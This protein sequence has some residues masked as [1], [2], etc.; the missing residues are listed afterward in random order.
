MYTQGEYTLPRFDPHLVRPITSKKR[1][2]IDDYK[3]AIVTLHKFI[4]IRSHPDSPGKHIEAALYMAAT[5]A[6]HRFSINGNP[7]YLEEAIVRY[8]DHLAY[9]SPGSFWHE[10]VVQSLEKL[11]R[12]RSNLFGVANNL[13]GVHPS[14]PQVLHFRPLKSPH[15]AISE[16]FCHLH[17]YNFLLDNLESRRH[18][19]EEVGA[20]EHMY[21]LT[22]KAALKRLPII[23]G[24]SLHP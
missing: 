14:I 10:P 20:I 21:L 3:Y 8:R 16:N 23:T 19:V 11:E 9:T 12:T 22:D 2:S 6:K 5:L 13:Q 24:P 17:G 7:E 1:F 18:Q 15:P 4:A